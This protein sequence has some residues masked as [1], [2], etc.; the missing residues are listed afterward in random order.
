MPLPL[1]M[2]KI[3][4]CN[5]LLGYKF[6]VFTPKAIENEILEIVKQELINK[7]LIDEALAS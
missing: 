1:R 6:I 2:K 4:Q 5:T 7:R 3:S